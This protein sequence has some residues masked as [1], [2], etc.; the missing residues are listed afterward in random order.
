VKLNLGCGY[1][2]LNGY[3]NIDCNEAVAPDVV[4]DFTTESFPYA[5]GS[6]QQVVMFHTIEHIQK[7]FHLGLLLEIR[8]VL[9]PEGTLLLSYPEFSKIAE[10]WKT[11]Y[12]GK[13]EFWEATIYGRQSS[14]SDFHVSLMDSKQFSCVL[15]SAG[16]HILHCIPEVDEP[17]NTVLKATSDI[18]QTYSDAV[19]ENVWTERQ[20]EPKS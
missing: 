20:L 13:R 2:K 3:V 17:Y 14:P 12:L 11:N 5:N 16:Y 15:I 19:R 1:E 9:Q 7:K 10:N 8:R 4:L 6:V 18:L